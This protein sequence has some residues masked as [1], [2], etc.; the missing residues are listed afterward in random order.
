[1]PGL[2]ARC[3]VEVGDRARDLEHAVVGAR[4][5]PEFFKGVFE[6]R[7]GVGRHAADL[8][9][10][11]GRDLRVAGDRGVPEA[12]QLDGPRRID[13]RLD[14]GGAFLL[15]RTGQAVEADGRHLD[16]QVDAVEQRAGNPA[17]IPRNGAV[18]AGAG[19]RRVA[20]VPAG[21][22]IHGGDQHEP[23]GEGDRAV[24]ARDGHGA[25]LQRLAQHLHGAAGKLGQLIEEQDAVVREGDLAGARYRAAARKAGGG[26]RVVRGAE[27]PVFDERRVV[28]QQA[29]DRVDLGGLHA[30]RKGHVGQNRG[31]ALCE[32]AFAGARR[33]DQKHVVAAA[34]RNLQR[35][36]RLRLPLH[37]G[38]IRQRG[39]C[40]RVGAVGLGGFY[41][42]M[43]AQ[44]LE[45][46]EN[47]RHRVDGQSLDD[48]ALPRVF[49]RDKHVLKA[50]AAGLDRHRQHAA[51]GAQRA[52]KRE[53][54]DK[55]AAVGAG[56]E[57][58]GH[59][60]QGDQQRQVVNRPLLAPVG[61]GE[62]HRDAADRKV[63][64]AVLQR[65][66]HA[67][68]RFLDGGVRQTDEVKG[69]EPGGDVGLHLHEKRMHAPKSHAVGFRYHSRHPFILLF[70][71][72]IA[73]VEFWQY[74]AEFV[75]FE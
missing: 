18:R 55:D 10:K 64:A 70:S 13:A 38:K 61:G 65:G 46:S 37:I 51:H 4:G 73:S 21:A 42:L 34:R 44:V 41:R 72:Y 29:R 25:V 24:D 26:D 3:V 48:R 22:R 5:K 40:L 6:Q 14:G 33:A 9:Q 1:M 62:V 19:A 39:L 71:Y 20:V 57:L 32:H 50:E 27:R 53:L 66:P 47:V 11:L 16:V 30:L 7:L 49:R 28:R 23:A 75:A 63:E 52:G 56:A 69:R 2:D 68:A 54:A 74:N 8:P 15:L 17:K 59:F 12:L 45:Q 31:D 43:P 35:A 60:Q 36:L 58:T 67:V